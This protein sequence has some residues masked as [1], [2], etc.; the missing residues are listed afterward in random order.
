[1]NLVSVMRERCNW[2][3]RQLPPSDLGKFSTGQAMCAKCHEWHG[4]A[5]AVLSGALPRGCQECG[6]S[7]DDL[8]ALTGGA[9]TR[10]YVVPKDGIYQVLCLT[11][12]DA[13]CRKRLDLYQNTK[14]GQHLARS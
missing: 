5:L 9:T 13:Y 7:L 12:K 11:C 4:H 2:C 14:F 8:N 1:M 3:S 6:I 10:M